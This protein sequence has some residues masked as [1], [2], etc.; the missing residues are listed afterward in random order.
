[1]RTAVYVDGANIAGAAR[2]EHGRKVDFGRL[3]DVLVRR[4]E[5]ALL[6]AYVIDNGS[7]GFASFHRA[8]RAMGYQ[9]TKRVPKTLPDGSMKADLDVQ[10]AVDAVG[11]ACAAAP[12][13]RVVI[14]TG[15]S[16]F[17]PLVRAL[18]ERGIRV[19]AAM[20][21]TRS[22]KELIAAVDAFWPLGEEVLGS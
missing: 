3:R 6:R 19:E 15:D 16:D 2:Q 10:L 20:F 8:L 14:V 13:S 22:A 18:K 4:D 1:V 21:R 7:D 17:V 5:S 9:V 11:D 12:P